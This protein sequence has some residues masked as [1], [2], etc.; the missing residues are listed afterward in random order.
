MKPSPNTSRCL[1]PHPVE[2]F[3]AGDRRYGQPD[4]EPQ[5]VYC[6]SPIDNGNHR[7]ATHVGLS[8]KLTRLAWP[9]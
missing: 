2:T 1:A 5:A 6:T 8:H 4:P 7:H 3:T 9:L